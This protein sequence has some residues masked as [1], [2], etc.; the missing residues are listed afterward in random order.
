MAEVYHT[1]N[2]YQL[3]GPAEN[4][5]R[6][7]LLLIKK[8]FIHTYYKTNA[9]R[10]IFASVAVRSK[11]LKIAARHKAYNAFTAKL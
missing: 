5:N 8:G 9:A 2:K 6:G 11:K 1:Q 3:N 10:K 7:R 4:K